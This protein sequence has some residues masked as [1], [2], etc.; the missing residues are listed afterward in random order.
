MYKKLGYHSIR[1]RIKKSNNTT[2][3]KNNNKSFLNLISHQN[4]Y[5]EEILTNIQKIY[6]LILF[7]SLYLIFKI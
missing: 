3:F 7:F 1:I 4:K 2:K 5:I 6:F